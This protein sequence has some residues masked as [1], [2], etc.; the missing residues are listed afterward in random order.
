LILILS[1]SPNHT[2]EQ[3]HSISFM[4]CFEIRKK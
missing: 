2:C 3:I 4:G 1:A